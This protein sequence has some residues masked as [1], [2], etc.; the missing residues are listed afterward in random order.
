MKSNTGE[1]L[2][3][4]K[5]TK[6]LEYIVPYLGEEDKELLKSSTPEEKIAFLEI[7]SQYADYGKSSLH[8]EIKSLDYIREFVDIDT[9]LEDPYYLG[10]IG[11]N[12]Y[13]KLRGDLREIVKEDYI[14]LIFSGSI[15]WGKS[16]LSRFVA[17]YLLYKVS[18][19]RDPQEYFNLATGEPIM[20]CN[21]SV[22][23][24]KSDE[25]FKNFKN[26][27]DMSKYF[28][29]NFP[30]LKKIE[31]LLLFPNNVSFISAGSS[32]TGFIGSNVLF[33]ILDEMN[34]MRVS[35][36][37]VKKLPGREEYNQA[38]Q[39][40]DSI[41]RRIKTTFMSYGKVLGKVVL[42]SS[43]RYPGDFLE[44]HKEKVKS[45]PKVKILEY[46][47]WDVHP[48]SK[49]S[50]KWFYVYL[51]NLTTQPRIIEEKEI[52]TY[53]EHLVI[54]VPI[55]FKEDFE[56]DLHGAIRD[57][58]GK[59][60]LGSKVY[61][62]NREMISQ[63]FNEDREIPVNILTTNLRDNFELNLDVLFNRDSDGNTLSLKNHPKSGRYLH[64]DL[65][66]TGDLTG[67][68]LGCFG[69]YQEIGRTLLSGEKVKE[70]LPITW[71]DLAINISKDSTI[72]EVSR[73]AIKEFI[74]DLTSLG[75]KIEL[76][77]MDSHQATG[78]KQELWNLGY[79]VEILSV[80]KDL[81]PYEQYKK[82]VLTG[83][84][85]CH[86][87]PTAQL[88]TASLY[89]DHVK[90]KIEHNPSGSKDISDCLAAVTYHVFNNYKLQEDL[91]PDKLESTVE[92]SHKS[93]KE[94][95]KDRR[96]FEADMAD[97]SD[98]DRFYRQILG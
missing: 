92:M 41:Q 22:V 4:F 55:D 30:R 90:N 73:I 87:Q 21:L 40:Y 36:D 39:M 26:L 83:R 47:V 53:S 59:S 77:T 72:G 20:F 93:I 23:G 8:Q 52:K 5:G 19:L 9:F 18:C 95:V 65:S 68:V 34:F 6:L 24:Q 97:L 91:I 58:A 54:K 1:D 70:L 37:S 43:A 85:S 51:G 56:R 10:G 13:P 78:L 89:H 32:E 15:R 31:S 84:F 27:I 88:E 44:K 60:V 63:A 11:K 28:T 71:I 69:G 76:I 96:F 49:Y 75:I 81:E 48:S 79:E 29:E 82:S 64:F 33:A 66:E 57:I 50:G 17:A 12:I 67:A 3:Y 7:L 2:K 16:F 45:D 98:T 42:I 62:P 38:L 94:K 25:F 46:A 61:I 74:Q 35:K 86:P 80:D 14:E